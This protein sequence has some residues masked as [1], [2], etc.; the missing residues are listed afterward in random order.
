M[1]TECDQSYEL[2]KWSI[3]VVAGLVG[4]YIGS[5]LS[6]KHAKLSR[7]HSY[8]EK[9]L[10][11]FYSPLVGLHNEIEMLSELRGKIQ[12]AASE[13]WKELCEEA[14]NRDGSDALKKLSD[15][16]YRSFGNIIE[17][18]NR[19]LQ[20]RL[21]PAY[22]QMIHIFR[23]NTWLAE[24]ETI[25]HFQNLLEFVDIWDRWLDDSMPV[26]VWR[27][28]KHAEGNLDAFCKHIEIT[29]KKLTE[30]LSSG[31]V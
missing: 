12:A 1:T 18:D 8:I 4:V 13:A 16:R 2:I 17:Y 15:E 27:K 25:E 28:L 31:E 21:L 23:E 7:K 6:G 19:A 30:K 3:S 24:G 20:E 14:R 10:S 5:W 11:Q 22:K 26:E 29:H 9:Q